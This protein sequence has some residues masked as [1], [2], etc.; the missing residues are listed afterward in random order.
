MRQARAQHH[1]NELGLRCNVV[2]RKHVNLV[3]FG[4]DFI[5]NERKVDRAENGWDDMGRKLTRRTRENRLNRRNQHLL[6]R[7]QVILF[8]PLSSLSTLTGFIY[9]NSDQP[10]I[11]RRKPDDGMRELVSR[12]LRLSSTEFS[13]ELYRLSF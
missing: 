3:H 9:R 1:R 11:V 12:S 7:L 8:Q 6:Q 10:W 4:N 2:F 13:R 5:V